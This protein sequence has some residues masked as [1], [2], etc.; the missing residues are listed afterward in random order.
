[1]LDVSLDE[2][3]NLVQVERAIATLAHDLPNLFQKDI[4]YDIY[5]QD[6]LFQDP[7]ICFKGK[8]SYRLIFWTLRFYR[9]LCFTTIC[10]NLHS[11]RGEADHTICAEWTVRG[12]L[13]LPWKPRLL[14]CGYSS[15]KLNREGLICE[16]IDIWDR[17][18]SQVLRQ[19]FDRN[20]LAKL[21]D[22]IS[23]V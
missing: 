5:S 8:P 7:V 23:L 12:T 13:R 14:F 4:C 19:F 11:V 20:Q 6:I 16:H 2:Q 17:P 3:P 18:P 10:F 21:E 9:R 15:Y 1:M 22:L